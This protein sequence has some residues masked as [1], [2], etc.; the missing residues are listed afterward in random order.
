MLRGRMRAAFERLS[1]A[2]LL[3]GLGVLLIAIN[4]GSAVWDAHSDRERMLGDVQRDVSNITSVLAEQ[5]A[6]GLDAVDLV[7]R[8]VQRIGGAAQIARQAARLRDEL[9]YVSQ[10]AAIL[11]FDEKGEVIARTNEAPAITERRERPFVKVHMQGRDIGVHVSEPYLGG[12]SNG[13]WRF[14][15]SRRLNG[16][17]GSFGGVVA[18]LVEIESYQRLYRTIDLG[19]GGFIGVFGADGSVMTRVPDPQ[20]VTGTRLSP[21]ATET[22][23]HRVRSGGRF[24]GRVISEVLKEPVVVSI[25]GVRNFP[26]YVATGKTENAA[27]QAWREE[28]RFTAER[29]LLT[30]AA[31]LALIALAAWGL[32]RRERALQTNERRF[33]SMI[34]NSTDA[35]VVTRPKAKGIV[36]TSPAFE[37]LTGFTADEVRGRQ[38]LEFIHPEQQAAAL[39]LR[40]EGLRTPG[41]IITREFLIRHRDGSHRW[42]EI[43]ASNLLD[44]PAVGALVINL[45]DITERKLAEAERARLETRLRQSAKMEA[46]GRLAGG[47]AHDFNNILGGILGYAEM[48]VEN[49]PPAS[50]ERR[51]A[52]NVLT[53]AERAS[54]L[55]EQILTYSRSQRGN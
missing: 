5:T 53:A 7:L 42:L 12:P 9:A 23:L 37:R 14:A 34:E 45:R 47:I 46:V 26:L 38:F 18:A 39:A 54:S 20:Q 32:N 25:A 29:T 3:I 19:D 33:R 24:D 15:M 49:A 1:L 40:D 4:I 43:T 51:Y 27:L 21:G 35:I 11:V 41:N 17:G 48:L 22:L 50:A 52:Q 30:S 44:D 2:H 31:M 10:V 16:P 36:Y 28:T 8:D 6:A 55:V 13:S